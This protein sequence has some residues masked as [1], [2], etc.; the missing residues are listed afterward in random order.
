MKRVA[1]VVQRCHESV[2]GGSEALAW[3]YARLLAQRHDV[4]VLTSTAIDYLTWESVLPAGCSEHAGIR[5]RRFPATIARG[6]YWTRLHQRL[7]QA[8][9][10]IRNTE[11][12]Q[13]DWREA[14]QDEFLRFQGPYCPGL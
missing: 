3:Q 2:V 1:I 12:S 5:I 13:T 9:G 14:L 7:M 10:A 8:A 6:A 11:G 4:E